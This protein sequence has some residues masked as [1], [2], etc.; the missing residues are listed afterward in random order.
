[1]FVF[2]TTLIH[3]RSIWKL[4]SF[5]FFS[6]LVVI[7]LLFHRKVVRFSVKWVSLRT[8]RAFI[9]WE[10]ETPISSFRKDGIHGHVL[11]H[12]AKWID[13]HSHLRGQTENSLLRDRDTRQALWKAHPVYFERSRPPKFR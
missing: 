13:W 12:A 5:G 6:L 4:P 1:M 8:F 2:S 7:K 10:D 11:R 9:L 3:L